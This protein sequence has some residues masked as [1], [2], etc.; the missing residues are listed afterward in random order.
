MANEA[1]QQLSKE[2]KD[3]PALQLTTN[4]HLPGRI[5]CTVAKPCSMT[6]SSR[7]SNVIGMVRLSATHVH[8]MPRRNC[9]I[10]PDT[11]VSAVPTE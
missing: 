1:G 6:S 4:N 7:P 10:G 5:N 8:F 2:R 11:E 3:L 9:N